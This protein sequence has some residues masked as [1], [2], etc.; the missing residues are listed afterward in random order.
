MLLVGFPLS[1]FSLVDYTFS[2]AHLVKVFCVVDGFRAPWRF[3]DRRFRFFR[4]LARAS[5]AKENAV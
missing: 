1:F 4:H 5:P 3:H 2:R